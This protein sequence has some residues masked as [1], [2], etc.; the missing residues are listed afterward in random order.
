MRLGAV[1]VESMG[2][3]WWFDE[4]ALE[5]LRLPNKEQPREHPEWGNADADPGLQDAVWHPYK[6]WEITTVRGQESV[7][8]IHLDGEYVTVAPDAKV[9][10]M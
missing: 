2:S 10:W 3:F 8:V 5:Y 7:L 9:V 1:K 6:K 4:Q